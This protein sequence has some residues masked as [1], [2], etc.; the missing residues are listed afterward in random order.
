MLT[1]KYNDGI[2]EDSRLAKNKDFFKN[3]IEG[4]KSDEGQSKIKRVKELT[5]IAEKLDGT[6]AQLA[7]AW[8]AKVSYEC[9]S[10]TE[11][12]TDFRSAEPQCVYRHPRCNEAR[13]SRGQLRRHQ[14]PAQA[15][16]RR[17]EGDRGHSGQQA[18]RK[19]P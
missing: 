17:Y 7:L 8:A 9:S 13:A 16:R 3:K 19:R 14:A 1:G 2:P 18:L 4:L 5:K 15:D 10:Y 11:D 12:D 6:M